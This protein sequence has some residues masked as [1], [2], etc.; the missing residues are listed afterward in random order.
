MEPEPLAE[1]RVP[2]GVKWRPGCP[3]R[4]RS[5][6]LGLVLRTPDGDLLDHHEADVH[7]VALSATCR[8]RRRLSEHRPEPEIDRRCWLPLP[9]MHGRH[10]GPDEHLRLEVRAERT[11]CP[12][13]STL[14]VPVGV[15]S[16]GSTKWHTRVLKAENADRAWGVEP[17]EPEPVEP[18]EPEPDRVEALKQQYVDGEIWLLELEQRLEAELAD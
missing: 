7:L 14:E 13:G 16:A 17:P 4:D 12:V 10:L 18:V 1:W 6:R 2:A 11:V 5:P 3:V 15:R 9:P 8:Q